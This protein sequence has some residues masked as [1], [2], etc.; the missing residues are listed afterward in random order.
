MS[1]AIQEWTRASS[2]MREQLTSEEFT[3]VLTTWLE[4]AS[5]ETLEHLLDQSQD[6]NEDGGENGSSN[7]SWL[8][9]VLKF[10]AKTFLLSFVIPPAIYVLTKRVRGVYI[11]TAPCGC[12]GTNFSFIS[13]RTGAEM[14]SLHIGGHHSG[15]PGD[16][17]EDPGPKS[18][19]EPEPEPEDEN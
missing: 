9:S 7:S 3:K 19:D 16:D 10:S 13:Q 18:D 14:F 12:G 1:K 17:L 5:P 6:G 4:S 2:K 15:D 11:A 8:K